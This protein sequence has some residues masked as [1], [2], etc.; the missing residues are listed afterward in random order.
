MMCKT[1]GSLNVLYSVQLCLMHAFD[2][3]T[4]RVRTTD[5][6][7]C[8]TLRDRALWR[9]TDEIYAIIHNTRGV[10]ASTNYMTATWADEARLNDITHDTRR[11]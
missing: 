11:G 9:N 1:C 8:A 7:R 6:A 4:N 5:S 3:P 10:W 2:V